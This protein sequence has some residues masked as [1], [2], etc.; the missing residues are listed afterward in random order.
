[1]FVG[2]ATLAFGVVALLVGRTDA[3]RRRV[4]ALAVAAG[5]FAALPDVDMVAALVVVVGVDPTQ[6]LA[7][8]NSF[9]GASTT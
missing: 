3:P 9:W 1:M 4:L 7:A 5:L 8:A 2:H 6:P